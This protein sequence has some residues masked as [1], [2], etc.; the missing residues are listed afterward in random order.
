M[1]WREV[2]DGKGFWLSLGWQV[3]KKGVDLNYDK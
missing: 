1:K 3:I 2:G